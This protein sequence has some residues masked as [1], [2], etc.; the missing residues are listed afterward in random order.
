MAAP[1]VKNPGSRGSD[2][3]FDTSAMWPAPPGSPG[4]LTDG[5]FYYDNEGRD[6][7]GRPKVWIDGLPGEDD[8]GPGGSGGSGGGG[9]GGGSLAQDAIN[10][11]WYQQALAA[12]N[13]ASA[14]DSAARR[15]AIQQMLIQ[16]GVV[17]EGFT[18]P[19]SD[20]DQKTRDLA[21]ANTASGISA[22]ARLEKALKDAQTRSSRSL[23]A[24]GL[25]RSGERGFQMRENQLG[26]DQS[27]SDAIAK[28]LSGTQGLYSNFAQNEYGR[29]MSLSQALQNAIQNMSQWYRPPR[30][31]G[32]SGGQQ[33]APDPFTNNPSPNILDQWS[34]AAEYQNSLGPS[35]T[36]GG[37]TSP[38]KPILM[39]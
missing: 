17:P 26:F 15:A 10:S 25:R 33:M 39:P 5:E 12:S 9:G 16:F 23:A 30:S 34:K 2:A 36:T 22:K 19:Y 37:Y 27:Y 31:G 13:A 32:S 3:R 18:D 28:L 38:K 8:N 21:A 24:R 7:G 29:Q 20:V 14:A 6:L 1:Q 11:P 4:P 35:L